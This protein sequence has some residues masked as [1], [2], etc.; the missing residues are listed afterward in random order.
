MRLVP[1]SLGAAIGNSVA[2]ESGAS[3]GDWIVT[4]GVNLL[5]P[6][7][8]VTILA[9]SISDAP[10]STAPTRGAETEPAPKS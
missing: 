8:R 2:I 1:V 9:D 6:D 10:A 3:A 5:K 7:Q 4:A